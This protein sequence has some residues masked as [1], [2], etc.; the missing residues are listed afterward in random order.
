MSLKFQTSSIN[1]NGKCPI[2]FIGECENSSLKAFSSCKKT[3]KFIN[4]LMGRIMRESVRAIVHVYFTM[5]TPSEIV[6]TAYMQFYA[7]KN[8]L[9][10][11]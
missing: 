9:E 8:L 3:V 1:G 2:M 7:L 5:G 4:H 6:F 10:S 11:T